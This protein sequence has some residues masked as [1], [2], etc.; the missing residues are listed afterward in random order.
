MGEEL[1]YYKAYPIHVAFIRGSSSDEEGNITMEEEV[2]TFSMLTLAQAAKVNGGIVIAQVKKIKRGF[3]AKPERVKVPGVMVDYII[4]DPNQ[5]MT[6]ITHFEEA[7]VDRT[8]PYKSEEL[9]LDGVKRVVSRRAALEIKKNGFINLGYGMPDGVPIVVHEEGL[10]KD[11]V[12]MIE[13]GQIDGILTTGLNFGAM[14]NPA[15][16]VDEGYQFD[17]F[18]GGGLDVC[19]LGFAQIDKE[20][21]VNSSR[22]GNVLTG[23][24]GFIDISQNAK[25][26]VFCGAFT[27]K[28]DI[29]VTENGLTI[30]HTG[31]FKKFV[32]KV[33]Q[34]SFSG[35]LAVAKKKEVYYVTE[36]AVFKLTENGPELIEIAPGADLQR[37]IL[38]MME[39]K[40]IISKNLK[41]M[42]K[43]IF[44][45]KNF[46][47][48]NKIS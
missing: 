37:D 10:K 32:N 27:A 5:S 38:D 24:G 13:Q 29:E 6:F 3:H 31:Q 39:F 21:N 2:G 22:F 42:D 36:R 11:V 19:Y 4:E 9:T 18:H 40:P 30:K 1:L 34:I 14:Y 12:F 15:A 23:C 47:L 46:N 8:A 7:L 35:K 20:G 33:Q 43:S 48:K 17:F 41:E 45:E 26:A 44:S 28:A 16:I 25:K